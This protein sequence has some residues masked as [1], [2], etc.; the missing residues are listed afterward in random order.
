M[1]CLFT[2]FVLWAWRDD[3]KLW[4]SEVIALGIKKTK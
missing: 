3:L 2:L 1:G 4:L